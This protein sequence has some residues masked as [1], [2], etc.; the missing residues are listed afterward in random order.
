MSFKAFLVLLPHIT[1]S[2]TSSGHTL[3]AIS[4]LNHVCTLSGFS[5]SE[6]ILAHS[7]LFPIPIFTV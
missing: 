1:N 2:P 4:S 6:A 3:E 5:K 7:L